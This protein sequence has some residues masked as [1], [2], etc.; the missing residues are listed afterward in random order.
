MIHARSR[1]QRR[2]REVAFDTASVMRQY[3][4]DESSQYGNDWTTATASVDLEPTRASD[5]LHRGQPHGLTDEETFGLKANVR[6]AGGGEDEVEL[7]N[8]KLAVLYSESLHVDRRESFL[9]TF[10]KFFGQ[11]AT[12][13]RAFQL[14]FDAY[15]PG[16]A[17]DDVP[18]SASVLLRNVRRNGDGDSDRAMNQFPDPDASIIANVDPSDDARMTPLTADVPFLDYRWVEDQVERGNPD[19]PRSHSVAAT[20]PDNS[21][22]RDGV[23]FE[24]LKDAIYREVAVFITCNESRPH[25]LLAFFRLAQCLTADHLRGAAV[26]ALQAVV[27]TYADD[28]DDDSELAEDDADDDLEDFRRRT[29]ALQGSLRGTEDLDLIDDHVGAALEFHGGLDTSEYEADLPYDC[30]HA[31]RRPGMCHW[32]PPLLTNAHMAVGA[33]M[34][35]C[36][37]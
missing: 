9:R 31:P 11:P 36:C 19:A 2:Q 14:S 15:G 18:D 4:N 26:D 28:E 16:S 23:L 5:V 32:K 13:A 17:H 20:A 7:Q 35:H 24:E 22:T 37:T 27:G 10:F 21:P 12:A 30:T 34:G 29:H 25:F 3:S 6:M 33:Q 8:M 1:Q